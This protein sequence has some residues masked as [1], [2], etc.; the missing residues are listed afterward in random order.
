MAQVFAFEEYPGLAVGSPPRGVGMTVVSASFRLQPYGSQV[1]FIALELRRYARRIVTPYVNTPDNVQG[2]LQIYVPDRLRAR[3]KSFPIMISEITR[4]T[5]EELFDS[6]FQSN[7][8]I[9]I[10]DVDFDFFFCR[11]N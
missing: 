1:S 5:I 7:D 6:L 9:E 10:T 8:D 11:S 2:W 4:Q 3:V